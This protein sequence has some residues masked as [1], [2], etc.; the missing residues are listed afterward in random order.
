M[1][2]IAFYFIFV[3]LNKNHTLFESF[4]SCEGFKKPY[5]IKK[6]KSGR[7]SRVFYV[8]SAGKNFILKHYFFSNKKS[9]RLSNEYNFL[10]YLKE[11]NIDNVAIPLAKDEKNG[12]ALYSFLEGE[13]TKNINSD[14]IDQVS[15]FIK[16]INK[17]KVGEN[18]LIKEAAESC[19]SIKEHILLIKKRLL[20]L[21]KI[22][23]INDVTDEMLKFLKTKLKPKFMKIYN[24]I[25]TLDFFKKSYGMEMR[26]SQK[27]LS[28]SDFGFQNILIN[29]GKLYFLDFEY[30]GLDDPAKL[31][32]DFACHPE[33][34]IK[35]DFLD[36]FIKSFF[37][38]YDYAEEAVKR[39]HY[40]LPFY[41]IK[42]CCIMLN[43]FTRTGI[44]RRKF[45]GVLNSDI[46]NAQLIKT[47]KYF[48]IHL[49]K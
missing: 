49:E 39:S 29:R 4:L 17:N 38:W 7:N 33:V 42:W 44:Q 32:C 47:Q 41:R 2:F 22:N 30:A 20:N 45:S 3:V 12:F 16:K 36:L 14:F 46:Q 40:L 28:P 8:K 18:I 5:R 31:I 34:P 21:E 25:E 11:I 27:I 37:E 19:F 43:E 9:Q 1:E 13:S 24:N 15:G 48:K 10:T 23:P 35:K 26:E 6:I